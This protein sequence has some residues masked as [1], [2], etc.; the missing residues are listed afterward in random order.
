MHV[1][2]GI[3]DRLPS[4]FESRHSQYVVLAE[5]HCIIIM[6]VIIRFFYIFPHP[7]RQMHS[8]KVRFLTQSP[9]VFPKNKQQ[10]RY[11]TENKENVT[12]VETAAVILVPTTTPNSQ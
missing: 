1:V 9:A 6:K 2:F 8:E 5:P 11:E 4:H 10:K 12:K 3:L 7:H